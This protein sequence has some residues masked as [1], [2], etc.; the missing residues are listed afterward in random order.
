MLTLVA[1]KPNP[2]SIGT[3]LTQMEGNGLHMDPVEE[4]AIRAKPMALHVEDVRDGWG[5]GSAL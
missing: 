2:D 4:A 3:Q 1:W 5:R